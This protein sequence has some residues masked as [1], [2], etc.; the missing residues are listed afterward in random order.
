[1]RSICAV[2]STAIA[3]KRALTVEQVVNASARMQLRRSPTWEDTC[4]YLGWIGVSITYNDIPVTQSD[5]TWVLALAFAIDMSPSGKTLNGIHSVYWNPSLT[6][7]AAKL[8]RVAH[9]N[10]RIVISIGGSQLY[11]NNG[12]TY[13]VNWYESLSGLQMPSLPSSPSSK[14]TVQMAS[15]LTLSGFP[16]ALAPSS[17]LSWS[18]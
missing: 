6:K 13:D 17:S 10:G 5:L 7:A 1:M 3:G 2:A 18:S 16:T 11:S 14:T 15:T 4:R 8:W 9:S 12:P